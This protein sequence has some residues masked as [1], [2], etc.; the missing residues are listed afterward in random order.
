M[1]GRFFK[2]KVDVGGAYISQGQLQPSGN[3]VVPELI[4]G[5]GRIIVL[6]EPQEDISKYLIVPGS[7]AEVAVY[8]HHMHHLAVL[9]KVLLRM[10]LVDELH[11]RRRPLT[12][13]LK[14]C[15]IYLLGQPLTS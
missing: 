8:T 5:E 4:K 6:I 13:A 2:A 7:S 3:L 11:L 1:P 10:K 15:K 12:I 9:R 14:L